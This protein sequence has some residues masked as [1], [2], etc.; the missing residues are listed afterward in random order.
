MAHFSETIQLDQLVQKIVPG[1]RLLHAWVLK[2]GI[3]AGMTALE[4]E[5]PD[6]QRRKMILRQPGQAALKQ[7]PRAAED[8][9]RLLEATRR[10]GLA[11]PTP[12]FLDTTGQ[13]FPAPYLVIEYVEGRPEFAPSNLKSFT[14]QL[15]EHL[16]RIH[17][18]YAS[19][20]DFSFL[21]RQTQGFDD[22]FGKRLPNIDPLVDQQ[23]VRDTLEAAWPIPQRNPTALLHGDYWPGNILWQADQLAA[24]IDWEDA[25]PGD[26]LEDLAITR[27]D[28]LWIFGR[29]AMESFSQA[30]Q[31]RMSLD[32][33]CLP[34]WDLFAA[35]RL[36][37]LA[38]ENL[39]EWAAF[40]RP[41]GRNDITEETI[42]THYHFFVARAMGQLATRAM[43]G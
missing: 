4:I 30:Y 9:F 33:T 34:Y 42:R 35:L 2:G 31:S 20:M 22:I 21:A 13:I 3:S 38:G 24:V 39:T 40:F 6:G 26:P 8:E 37:R 43:K 32:T 15:A 23:R 11:T 17:K 36:A 14:T 29:D 1:S 16:S 10:L 41:F 28:L 27:L 19:G 7:N 12:Y 25:K 18:A 5:H